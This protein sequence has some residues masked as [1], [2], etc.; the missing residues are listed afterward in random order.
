MDHEHRILSAGF[1]V[2][3][4]MEAVRRTG[5]DARPYAFSFSSDSNKREK[6]SQHLINFSIDFPPSLEA[7]MFCD[8]GDG[9]L[10]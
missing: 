4:S 6:R 9:P 8:S 1:D 10:A 3:I 2:G 7:G 5:P